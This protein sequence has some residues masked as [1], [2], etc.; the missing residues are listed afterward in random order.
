MR[1]VNSIEDELS[2]FHNN[3]K[4]INPNFLYCQEEHDASSVSQIVCMT[5][6]YFDCLHC[7]NWISVLVKLEPPLSTRP[8]NLDMVRP[9]VPASEDSSPIRLNPSLQHFNLFSNS[10]WQCSPWNP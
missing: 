6:F 1:K 4:V 2:V 10:F 5:G 7:L 3:L 8:V 9:R